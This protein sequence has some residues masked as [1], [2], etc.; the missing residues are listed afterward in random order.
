MPHRLPH[1]FWQFL[2]VM[3]LLLI[4][5]RPSEAQ[6]RSSSVVKQ[7]AQFTF[8]FDPK[9]PLSELLPAPPKTP[10]KMTHWANE[11]LSKV[12][13]GIRLPSTAQ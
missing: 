11:D 9:A 7:P 13:E 1:T 4:A 12:T 10:A 5:T 2:L 8:K 6:T 3:V